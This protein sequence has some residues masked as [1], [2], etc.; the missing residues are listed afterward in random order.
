MLLKLSETRLLLPP[1]S[2]GDLVSR[3]DAYF[4]LERKNAD[5]SFGYDKLLAKFGA[6]NKS[7]LE[8]ETLRCSVPTCS[9]CK[10]SRLML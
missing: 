4:R 3:K 2:A 5:V 6:Y 10:V 7:A 9:M 8:M 1:S